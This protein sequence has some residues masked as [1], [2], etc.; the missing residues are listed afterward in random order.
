[1]NIKFCTWNIKGSNNVVKRKAVLNHL[2][3]E[4]V[5]VAFL[6][7]T[8]LNEEEHKK[9][10]REWVGQVYFTSY[11]TNKRGAIILIHRL[12]PFIAKDSYK[13]TDGRIVLV[14]GEL[15]GESVLLGNVYAP[16]V[17][18]EDFFGFLLSKI[19]EMDCTNMIIGGDFN[20]YLSPS[21]DKDPPHK[22][23]SKSGRALQ[24]FLEILNY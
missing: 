7:E 21:L 17:Y 13:D 11:S 24:N 4:N 14:K 12:L 23:Q 19:A 8:H 9:C 1:M 10:L 16:N 22:D 15:Y 3:K 2:K 6:Q 20:C 5:Q 18:D